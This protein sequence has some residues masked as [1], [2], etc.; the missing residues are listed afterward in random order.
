MD[1]IKTPETIDQD[2]RRL[3]GTAA[4]ASLSRAQRACSRQN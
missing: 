3:L 1:T 2:R 4:R